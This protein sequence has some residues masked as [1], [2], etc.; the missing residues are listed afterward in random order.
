MIGDLGAPA[1]PAAAR[2]EGATAVTADGGAGVLTL[3]RCTDARVWDELVSGLPGATPFHLSA[4]L[5][6]AGRALGLRVRPALAEVGGRV[7]GAVPMLIAVR[8][9]FALVNHQLPF[10]YLGPLLP[11]GYSLDAVLPAVRRHLR[12]RCVLAFG[13]QSA[14][15]VDPPSGPGWESAEHESA[16][17]PLTGCDDDAL[18]ARMGKD[19]RA[20]VRKGLRAGLEAGPVTREEV[21]AHLPAWAAEA[22]GRQGLPPRW[23]DGA[24]LAIYDALASRGVVVGTA[25]RKDG[26]PVGVAV[27]LLFGGR[28]IGWE[29]GVSEC[30]RAL[31]AAP[32]LHYAVMRAARDL[33]AE[34][35]DMLGAPNP[36][37][38][39]YKRSLGAEFRPRGVARW[40]SPLG[41]WVKRLGRRAG[42]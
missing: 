11:E 42:R 15:P 16:Y 22:F 19:Q 1:G 34:E 25:V 38:A 20:N 41:L 3:R 36:G 23:P 2:A 29:S 6:P 37:I 12:G 28:L 4:F 9:P 7:V 30:G 39:R 5:A 8:G 33:G 31:R 35:L 14:G 21:A 26:E 40:R 27:D 18:L 13:V 10:P 17:V 32:V 24:H